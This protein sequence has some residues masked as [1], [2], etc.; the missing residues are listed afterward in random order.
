MGRESIA[1]VPVLDMLDH[2]PAAHVAW[3]SGPTGTENFQFITHSATKQATSYLLLRCPCNR[4][5]FKGVLL[6]QGLMDLM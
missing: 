4:S 3:H 6:I 5:S 1:L 2:S